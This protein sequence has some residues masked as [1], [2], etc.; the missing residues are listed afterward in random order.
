MN[1][2][3]KLASDTA[4][5]AI[6][7][8]AS[9]CIIFLLLPLYTNVLST[10]EYGTADL[11]YNVVNMVYPVMTLSIVEAALR[12]AFEKDVKKNEILTTAISFILGGTLILIL[13]SPLRYKF[14]NEIGAYWYWFVFLF[15]GY[16]LQCCFSYYSRGT[17]KTK[18]F[19]VQGI[20][21]TC[22]AIILNIILLLVFHMGI[23]GYLI[24]SIASYYITVIFVIVFGGYFKDI[25]NVHYNKKLIKDML[26]YSVPIIPSSVAWWINTSADRYFIIGIIGIGASGVYSAANKIPSILSVVTEIFN[27]AWQITA[28]K[29]FE[30][31]DKISFYSEIS[32]YFAVLCIG[33]CSILITLSEFIGKILFAKQYF[34]GW[35]YV[36]VLL[37][38]ALFSSLSSFLATIF[39]TAKKTNILFIS[40]SIG[41]AVN[42]SLNYYFI[43][44]FGTVGAAYSTL[45]SFIIV[46]VTRFISSR[47]IIKIKCNYFKIIGSMTLVLVQ[48]IIV[49]DNLYGKY[50]ISITVIIVLIIIN[51][52]EIK[53]ILKSLFKLIVS[54]K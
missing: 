5:F 51:F 34:I 25:I 35:T 38:A 14:G 41:A 48:S 50:I 18:L 46:F 23:K 52:K 4:L 44:Q 15:L 3:K 22:L 8:F 45:I 54:R 6:S 17:N 1:K 47:K 37:F 13:I 53:N 31:N 43:K 11:L 24:A 16:S 21:H 33:A 26:I 36:P 39:R 28:I 10:E 29:S 9:K 12:F 32:T 2:Y 27:Q 49:A 20:V 30:D 42:I 40:T 19:A 7:S